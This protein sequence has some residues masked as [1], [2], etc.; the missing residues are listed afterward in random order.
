MAE[1]ATP[2]LPRKTRIIATAGPSCDNLDQMRLLA[3]AGV[4]IFR[5]NFTH[6]KYDWAESVVAHVRQLEKELGRPLGISI[7]TQG[8]SIRTGELA[9]PIELQPGKF[10]TF[11]VCGEKPP[12]GAGTTVQYDGFVD[13][14]GVGSQVLV[15][16][17]VIRMKV[18]EKKPHCAICEILTPGSF[19]SRRHINLPG[20]HINLPT[21]TEK[22]F[23][24]IR[25]AI[26]QKLNFICLSFI[27]SAEDVQQLRGLL[28]AEKSAIRIIAKIECP[29]A[30]ENFDG[31]LKTADGIMVARGD[32]GVELPYEELPVLQRQI[33]TKCLKA[34]KP[35]IVAT[36]MLESMAQN[37]MP[38]R[39]EVT[40]VTVAVYEQADAVMLS[41]ETSVGRY[42]V[43]CIETLDTIAR[44]V[45]R[46]QEHMV[47]FD[48]EN[49]D[50][51][52]RLMDAAVVLANDLQANGIV[53]F[54]RTGRMARMISRLRP[55]RSAIYAFTPAENVWRELC[56]H[57]GV[58]SFLMELNTA[59]PEASVNSAFDMLKKQGCVKTGGCLVLASQVEAHGTLHY[60]IQ[61][62]H[63]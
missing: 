61:P 59:D 31:L 19:G 53:V 3:N 36:Q 63:V 32:L 60:A 20:S 41:G 46:D 4:D 42:P 10:F 48:L 30:L 1:S 39:A 52:Q 38:T 22:D 5:L 37:P 34:G 26:Q 54:T 21:I 12:E 44:R 40:D 7:D 45:E 57:W 50:E 28:N 35:V 17:G 23:L 58:R 11:T 16:N 43:K 47:S 24:D 6:A 55:R 29:E 25:W 15:D 62:R 9:S 13:D 8:P 56:L 33:V 49:S 2:S 18:V 14:V 27:R 51:L